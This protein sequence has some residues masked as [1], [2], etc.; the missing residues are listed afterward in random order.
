MEIS[1][2]GCLP[3]VVLYA[4]FILRYSSPES[5]TKPK[6]ALPR[7]TRFTAIVENALVATFSNSPNVHED[8]ASVFLIIQRERGSETDR[9][10]LGKTR[11]PTAYRASI[12]VCTNC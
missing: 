6:E 4:D 10:P 1:R 2:S 7:Q 5:A 11:G 3:S 9:T 12:R 8:L